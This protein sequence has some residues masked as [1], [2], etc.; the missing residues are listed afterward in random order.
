VFS[1]GSISMVGTQNMV[2]VA[3]FLLALAKCREHAQY[4]CQQEAQRRIIFE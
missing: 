1:V 4:Q 2:F 3:G